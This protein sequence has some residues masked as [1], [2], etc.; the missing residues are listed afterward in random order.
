MA[1]TCQLYIYTN[2]IKLI[3]SIQ[4]IVKIC[5]RASYFQGKVE[6]PDIGIVSEGG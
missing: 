4:I 3:L 6:Q 1:I 5:A 2:I